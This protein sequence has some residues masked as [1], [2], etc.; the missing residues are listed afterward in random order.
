M[1][2]FPE[3]RDFAGVWL[4][5]LAYHPV[6][7]LGQQRHLPSALSN[8]PS[9]IFFKPFKVSAWVTHSPS[10]RAICQWLKVRKHTGG[11][12]EDWWKAVEQETGKNNGRIKRGEKR[13]W[14]FQ[15]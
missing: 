14:Y 9:S 4:Y 6:H 12:G 11:Q 5:S 2:S 15:I 13:K 10:T 8:L 1:M 3:L 7:F